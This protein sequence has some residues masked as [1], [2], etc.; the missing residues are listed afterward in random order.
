MHVHT[1]SED[2]FSLQILG[3]MRK[4][5]LLCVRE[6]CPHNFLGPGYLSKQENVVTHQMKKQQYISNTCRT[7]P[8]VSA[9]GIACNCF[10]DL[11]L[12]LYLHTICQHVCVSRHSQFNLSH[13]ENNDRFS[14]HVQLEQHV[15]NLCI[16]LHACP[17]E[18]CISMQFL[19]QFNLSSFKV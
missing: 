8:V 12:S 7:D 16:Y 9:I 15:I 18:R 1:I 6:Q 5:N 10:N 3:C 2:N 11:S 14:T 19:A 17:C 13:V 4:D